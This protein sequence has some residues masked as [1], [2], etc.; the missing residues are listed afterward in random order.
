MA[1]NQLI[2]G[3]GRIRPRSSGS[4]SLPL[5]VSRRAVPGTAWMLTLAVGGLEPGGPIPG[6]LPPLSP[7]NLRPL[8][9]LGGLFGSPHR[10]RAAAGKT[11]V[12]VTAGHWIFPCLSP[13]G[14]R[15]EVTNLSETLCSLGY[16]CIKSL[17]TL[18]AEMCLRMSFIIHRDLQRDKT[19]A[20]MRNDGWGPA[21]AHL[22][23][24]W[25]C[26]C[27]FLP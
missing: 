10:P 18:S 13:A 26:I 22:C 14:Y 3:G 16:G 17:P 15:W 20:T 1:N 23:R 7:T 12:T 6:D 4:E 9:S 8:S 11:R 2:S 25:A 5:S 24:L 27:L 21:G 19:A